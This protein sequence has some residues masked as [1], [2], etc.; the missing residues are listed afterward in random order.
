MII[1]PLIQEFSRLNVAD[2]P[3]FCNQG[4]RI[5]IRAG[6]PNTLGKKTVKMVE[7]RVELLSFELT[8]NLALP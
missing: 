1:S 8:V 3:E 6:G 5:C 4:A 2:G 7:C